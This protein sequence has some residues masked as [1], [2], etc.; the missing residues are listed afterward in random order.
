MDASITLWDLN[1]ETRNLIVARIL[2]FYAVAE[3]STTQ[4]RHR[5]VHIMVQELTPLHEH[6]RVILMGSYFR[7]RDNP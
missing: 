6:V 1:R 7:S 2:A 3:P 4:T 5:K